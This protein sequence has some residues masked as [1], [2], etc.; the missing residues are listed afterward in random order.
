[1]QPA[2]PRPS[3]TSVS[4]GKLEWLDIL[5]PTREDIALLAQKY[6][7]HPLNLEDCL[8]TRQLSRVED[9]D[10]HLFILLHFPTVGQD[11]RIFR[12]Q[13]SMFVG[14]GYV[15]T[16]H[17]SNLRAVRE[18][19]EGLKAD[20]GRRTTVMRS[21]G[22]I[23]YSVVDMLVDGIFPT[24]DKL[25]DDLDD[26]EDDVFDEKVSPAARINSLRREIADLRRITL[27]LP[28]TLRDAWTRVQRYATKDLAAYFKDVLDHADK[29]TEALE[30]SDETIEIYKD[31]NFLLNTD[32]TNNVL[33]ILTIIFTLTLPAA[34]VAAVYGMNVALP[35][36][37]GQG[38]PT[39]LGPYTS[40]I[41]LIV[42]M[43]VP[44]A[45]MAWYFRRAGWL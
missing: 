20:E 34:V 29:V 7:F 35:L 14:E 27:P 44:A 19:A 31:T 26:I 13:L 42:V 10:S 4:S 5:D 38:L 22:H 3:W 25:R 41:L 24:L 33:T 28:S 39:F 43:V 45:L 6:P 8:S 17:G 12:N 23:V 36:G 32:R 40:F 2:S 11:G 9:H 18:M 37:N 16:L 15:V 21:S 1:M 30:Q